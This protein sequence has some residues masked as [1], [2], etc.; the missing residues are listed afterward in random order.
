[1][2]GKEISGIKVTY[3]DGS[4]KELTS[5]CCVDLAD[6]GD[7]MSVEMLNI[8]PVDIVRLAYGLMACVDR[9][10]M[11]DAFEKYVTGGKADETV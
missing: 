2:D 9:M 10:G 7:E 6:K 11:M 1:M 4:I 3:T 5:G 8:K